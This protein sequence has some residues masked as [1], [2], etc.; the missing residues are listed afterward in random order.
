MRTDRRH[1]DANQTFIVPHDGIRFERGVRCGLRGTA[2][3]LVCALFF[4]ACGRTAA[5]T[6][7]PLQVMTTIPQTHTLPENRIVRVS[8]TQLLADSGLPQALQQAFEAQSDYRLEFAAAA[9]IAAV[10]VAQSGGADLLLVQPSKTSERFV[11]VG[12]GSQS[13]AWLRTSLILAGPADDPADVRTAD[14]AAQAMARIAE[15]GSAF[16]SRYDDSD[17][18]IAEERLWNA[19]GIAIGNGRKWY[20]AARMEMAGSLRMADSLGAYILCE[21]EIFLQNRDVFELE[22]LLDGVDDLT[23]RYC[24]I[25]VSADTSERVNAPGAAALADWLQSDEALRVIQTYGTDSY[26]CPIFDPDNMEELQ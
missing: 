13:I 5:P 3:A 21:K 20:K 18:C 8:V 23:V 22:N 1:A 15:T 9:D 11:S 6:D 17:L 12:D 24:I 26:G 7:S 14:T 25:P 2:L 4:C 10:A 19:A 16:V